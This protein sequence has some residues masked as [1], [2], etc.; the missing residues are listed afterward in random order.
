MKRNYFTLTEGL[1]ILLL[2]ALAGG[3]YA[4]YLHDK[5]N[6]VREEK[7]SRVV[8][9]EQKIAVFQ[10]EIKAK[11]TELTLASEE[12]KKCDS[13]LDAIDARLKASQAGLLAASQ[14]L[15]K[16]RSGLYLA[17]AA[18]KENTSLNQIPS[19]DTETETSRLRLVQKMMER[20]LKSLETERQEIECQYV[21]LKHVKPKTRKQIDSDGSGESTEKYWYCEEH[22]FSF[23]SRISYLDYKSQAGL[24]DF[25]IAECRRLLFLQKEQVRISKKDEPVSVADELPAAPQSTFDATEWNRRLEE[26]T[27]EVTGLRDEI[28]KTEK[29]KWDTLN[30]RSSLAARVNELIGQIKI[31]EGRILTQKL[32]I[33]ENRE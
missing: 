8:A 2:I 26:R 17:Q 14:A 24:L 1:F 4:W 27:R 11:K 13:E 25:Q 30:R 5:A 3:G 22:K 23:T 20:R 9:A 10:D 6:R 31:N 16:V 28:T 7:A 19:S 33:A 15:L 32:V 29:S 12:L 21:C 18:M